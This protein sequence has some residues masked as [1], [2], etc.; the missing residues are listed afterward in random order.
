MVVIYNN[1]VRIDQIVSW[2]WGRMVGISAGFR[3]NEALC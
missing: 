2:G 1:G 3:T